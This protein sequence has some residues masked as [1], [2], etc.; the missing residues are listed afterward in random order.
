MKILLYG[1]TGMVGQ[2][3]L[4]ECLKA[5]DVESVTVVVRSPLAEKNPRLRQIVSET[6]TVSLPDTGDTD[7]WDACFYCV[8]VS[9][10]GMT[11]D[12]YCRLTCN[13]TLDVATYLFR[14]NPAMMFIYVSA[15]G[16]D[17]SETAKTMWARVKGRTE[18]ALSRLGFASAIMFRPGIIQPLDGIRS[19]TFLYRLL[20]RLMAPVLPMLKRLLPDSILTTEEIGRAMLNAVRTG[21]SNAVLEKE[22]ICRLALNIPAP[23][24]A[25]RG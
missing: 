13:L 8:G 2:G 21:Y 12:D 18:N 9:A 19:R 23:S 17:T 11:E 1:S 15:A 22:D 14:V 4:R 20:Y 25:G 16:A 3:V 7:S 10:Y 6:L 5:S 24:A